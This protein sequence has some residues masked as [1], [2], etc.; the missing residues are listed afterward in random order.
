MNNLIKKLTGKN[1]AEY[2]DAAKHII[3][4]ADVNAFEE[5]V[6]QDDFLFDFVKNNVA[7]R[8]KQACNKDNFKNLLKFLAF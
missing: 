3:S 5:L 2:T 4:N 7:K 6:N 8:L 1:Q